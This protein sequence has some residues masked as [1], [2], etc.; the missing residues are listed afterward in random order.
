MGS[1]GSLVIEHY[2]VYTNLFIGSVVCLH[3]HE[4]VTRT[5]GEL[6]LLTRH[7][8]FGVETNLLLHLSPPIPFSYPIQHL[9]LAEVKIEEGVVCQVDDLLAEL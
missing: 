8:G 2:D 7:A 4:S 3:L 5:G 1:F 6:H 9:A